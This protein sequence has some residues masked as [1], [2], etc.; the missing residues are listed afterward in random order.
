MWLSL[1]AT[2]ISASAAYRRRTC[3][4][5]LGGTIKSAVEPPLA[6]TS[7]LAS[8]WPFVGTTRE[9]PG[10]VDQ[11]LGG[12][13]DGSL[14]VHLGRDGCAHG[15]VQVGAGEPEAGLRGLDQHVSQDWQRRLGRDR[16]RHCHQA[17]LQ[18]LPGDR[19]LHAAALPL[20]VWVREATS[21]LLHKTSSSSRARG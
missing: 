1:F 19:E 5:A 11:L 6:G 21:I 15:D 4:S 13:R 3:S 12:Q 9:L 17:F 14:H 16:C 20:R 2:S 7:I 18:L 8:R 10:D